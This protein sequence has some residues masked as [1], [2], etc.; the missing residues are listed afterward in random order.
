MS[1]IS[2]RMENWELL[3]MIQGFLHQ[4]N[5]ITICTV[6]NWS[7]SHWNGLCVRNSKIMCTTLHFSLFTWTTTHCPIV[8]IQQSTMQLAIGGLVNSQIFSLTQNT[9]PESQMWMQTLCPALFYT[10]RYKMVCTEELS[11]EAAHVAWDGSQAAKCKD[12]AWVAALNISSPDLSQQLNLPTISHD[13]L[14]EALKENQAIN[15]VRE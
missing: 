6:E 13:D 10:E 3:D 8:W 14:V 9:G 5:A 1:F 2:V 7:F 15:Q 12:V 11:D 4:L